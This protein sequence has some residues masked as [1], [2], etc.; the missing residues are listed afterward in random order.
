MAGQAGTCHSINNLN[1]S[2]LVLINFNN[3]LFH[4]SG[5]VFNGLRI[6]ELLKDGDPRV[7]VE[8]DVTLLENE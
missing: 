4:I 6:L 8:G 1:N 7:R 2:H 3:L 5:F